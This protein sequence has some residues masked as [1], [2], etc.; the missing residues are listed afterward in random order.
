M[1]DAVETPKEEPP[2]KA[3][4][5][6]LIFIIGGAVVAVAVVVAVLFFTGILGG[7]KKAEGGE[8]AEAHG[9]KLP[10][11][12]KRPTVEMKE[13]IINLADQDLPR[14]LKVVVELEV[15]DD[16]VAKACEANMASFRNSLVDLLSSKTFAQIRDIKGKTRLRQ[17]MIMRLNEIL[18]A[19]GVLQVYFTDF[20]VQ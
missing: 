14:Y 3:G 6:K 10:D 19:N 13:F 5:K 9:D 7:H 12:E 8:G 4:G 18:G 1:A 15:A 2:K 16:V 20:V 17:E 11:K